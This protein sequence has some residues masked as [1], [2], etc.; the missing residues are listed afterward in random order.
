MPYDLCRCI[1]LFGVCCPRLA[2]FS[3]LFRGREGREGEK[4]VRGE[5]E[6]QPL[7]L[8]QTVKAKFYINFC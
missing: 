7:L 5:G 1:A 4:R 3:G 2:I 6:K 8:A